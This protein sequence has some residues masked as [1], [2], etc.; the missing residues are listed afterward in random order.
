MATRGPLGRVLDVG[1]GTGILAIAARRLG[2]SSVFA[3]DL[4][5][6]SVTSARRHAHL[7]GVTFRLL[8]GD[9]GQPFRSAAFDVVLANISAPLL[10]ERCEEIGRLAKAGGTLVLAGLLVTDLPAVTEAYSRWGRGRETED[11]EWASLT[12]RAGVRP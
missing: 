7:N 6:E 3:V 5:P 10:I 11:G 1:T 12:V 4:D 8:R 2:A 9:G